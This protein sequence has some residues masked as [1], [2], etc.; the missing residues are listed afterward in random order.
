MFSCEREQVTFT[1]TS[2]LVLGHLTTVS[3]RD[4]IIVSSSLPWFWS[5]KGYILLECS[6]KKVETGPCKTEPGCSRRLHPAENH[7][8]YSENRTLFFRFQ[9]LRQAGMSSQLLP[10]P[11]PSCKY[12]GLFFFSLC[13]ILNLTFLSSTSKK[14]V[15]RKCTYG[16]TFEDYIYASVVFL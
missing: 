11:H 3:E 2:Q 4:L 5:A 6:G 7:T 15:L 1:V 13:S 14:N 8:H 9:C 12:H 16:N 10:S